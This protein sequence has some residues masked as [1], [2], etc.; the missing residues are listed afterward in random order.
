MTSFLDYLSVFRLVPITGQRK[1]IADDPNDDK[2]PE[3]AIEARAMHIVTGDRRHLLSLGSYQG[4][5][6]VSSTERVAL[7]AR[8]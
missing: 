8:P 6:I 5:Q 4:V 2:V 7:L 1:V 3:C